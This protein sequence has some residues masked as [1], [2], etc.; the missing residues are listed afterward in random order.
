LLTVSSGASRVP[1]VTVPALAGLT[2]KEAEATLKATGL[3]TGLISES[4]EKVHPGVVIDS[5]PTAGTSVE[6]GST[7][8]LKISSGAR[9]ELPSRV[10]VPALAGLTL[11]EAEATLKATGLAAEQVSEPSEKVPPG[12]VIDST[13]TAGTSVEKGSTVTLKVS[14]RG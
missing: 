5:T 9:S 12:V 3:G 4:S 2:A 10:T 6:K 14:G 1:L 11:E 8:T 13:P 7:V